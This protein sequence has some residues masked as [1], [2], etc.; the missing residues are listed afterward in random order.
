METVAPSRRALPTAQGAARISVSPASS[1][2]VTETFRDQPGHPSKG[3]NRT[4]GEEGLR[5]VLPIRPINERLFNLLLLENTAG[6]FEKALMTWLLTCSS[7]ER[8]S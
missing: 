6:D 4:M 5:T 1:A 2:P 3:T 8:A 7:C